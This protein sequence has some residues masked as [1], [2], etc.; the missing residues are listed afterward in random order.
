TC[1]DF[2]AGI[3][4]ASR[5]LS[6]EKGGYTVG[7][8]VQTNH[9]NREDLLIAGV[10]VGKEMNREQLPI[11][12]EKEGDGS[13]LIVVATDA[14]VTT[15]IL[16]AMAKRAT[17]GLARTGSQGSPF[18]GDVILAF[19]TLQFEWSEDEP[20]K[21]VNLEYLGQYET[22]ALYSA[23]IQA[24]EEAIINSIVAGKEMTGIYGTTFYGIDHDRVKELLNKYH[25]LR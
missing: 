14:P 15:E 25:R 7:V 3:G 19:S 20:Y 17:F 5:V 24:T 10:P 11:I 22:G 8:L 21:R 12:N 9:G 13:I 1:Y 6:P 23:T 2:K 16:Q 4:T 18:S